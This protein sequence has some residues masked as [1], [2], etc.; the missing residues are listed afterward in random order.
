M[1]A[2]PTQFKPLLERLRGFMTY[3]LAVNT[4]VFL[5]F[6]VIWNKSDLTN[7]IFKLAFVTLLICNGIALANH[8]GYIVKAGA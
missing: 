2:Y 8:V 3:L 5:Y 1:L 4:V 7:L 6:G